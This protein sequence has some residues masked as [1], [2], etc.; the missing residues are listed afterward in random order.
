[1]GYIQIAGPARV[2]GYRSTH[3]FTVA[4]VSGSSKWPICD[5]YY[6][7]TGI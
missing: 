6:S 7:S 5:K 4:P 3:A 2:K 1:M